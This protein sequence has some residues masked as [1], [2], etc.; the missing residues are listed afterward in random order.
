MVDN[1]IRRSSTWRYSQ[2][3]TRE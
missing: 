1:L 3:L 2:T